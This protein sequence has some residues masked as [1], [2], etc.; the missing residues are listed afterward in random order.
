MENNNSFRSGWFGRMISGASRSLDGAP[1]RYASP[2]RLAV[3]RFFRRPAACAALAVIVSMFLFVFLGPLFDP[4]DLSYAEPLHKN[5]SPSYD[6][7]DLPSALAEDVRQ[8]SSYS[9]LSLGL[10]G[11]GH[12]YT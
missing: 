3:L 7:M 9:S 2:G 8:I 5:L 4:I 10:D 1:D 6:M 12:V 11:T